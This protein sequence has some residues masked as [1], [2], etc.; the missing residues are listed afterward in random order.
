MFSFSIILMF[1]GGVMAVPPLLT[2]DPYRSGECLVRFETGVKS[3]TIAP[4]L[5]AYGFELT[6][7][8]PWIDFHIVSFDERRDVFQT[9]AALAG[10][11]GIALAE[12]NAIAQPLSDPNDQIYA[13]QWNLPLIKVD[14]VWSAMSEESDVTVAVLDTG[15]Y[16]DHPDLADIRR[17]P[18]YDTVDEDNDPTDPFQA[19]HGAHVSSIILATKDNGIG[20]A[21]VAANCRL[22]P[23]RVIGPGGGTVAQ[24]VNGIEYARQNGADVINMS[25]GFAIV[26][27]IP[28]DPGA[29]FAE[30][31]QAAAND[32]MVMVAAAGNSG[33]GIVVF[34]A[35]YD[36]VIAVGAV[37]KFRE[38]TDYSNFGPKLELVA[39]GGYRYVDQDNDGVDDGVWGAY[40]SPT[41]YTYEMLQGTSQ[42]APHV[43]GLAALLMAKGL[44]A[45]AA[46]TT[47]R[48]TAMDLGEAGFDNDYGYGLID[49]NEAL[50]TTGFVDETILLE[51]FPNPFSDRTRIQFTLAEMGDVKLTIYNILGQRVKRL[52][53]AE[54][55]AGAYEVTWEGHNDDDQKV[56]SGLYLCHF[57][58]PGRKIVKTLVCFHK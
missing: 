2:A 56:A 16:P 7:S 15:D 4:V 8:S 21:G 50:A 6:Y 58:A 18:G 27:G 54:Y 45:E 49:F 24:I 38:K 13:Q 43:S 57:S 23:V 28:V 17:V 55:P 31:I 41:G 42:A 14:R 46:R 35:R 32:D 39:P 51:A 20:I 48:L 25:F 3:S 33:E 19:S 37:D 10:L 9:C 52:I 40:Q 44:H 26:S 11:P 29:I 53:A 47:M 22:M 5:T 1:F 30:A 12:P 34:P 36:Q